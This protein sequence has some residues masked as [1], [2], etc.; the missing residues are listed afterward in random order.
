[1]A[2]VKAGGSA[3]MN[4]DSKPKHL[5]VKAY[6]GESVRPGT[7]IV[8]QKGTKFKPGIGVKLAGDYTIFA[9][10]SGV[11]SFFQRLG[12]KMVSVV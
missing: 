7:I 8:R 5:G 4:R 10:K 12:K 9:V 3:R 1:M 6:S 2:H 11:V